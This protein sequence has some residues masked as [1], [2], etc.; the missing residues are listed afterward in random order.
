M[1]NI[2]V[3]TVNIDG[4]KT[5]TTINRN[6]ATHFALISMTDD[7]KQKLRSFPEDDVKGYN[8]F[9]NYILTK[10]AQNLVNEKLKTS[11]W[12]DKFMIESHILWELRDYKY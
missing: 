3:N 4:K 8:D 12:V 7:E 2:K 9:N 10:Y 5:S 6:I 1:K 11:R